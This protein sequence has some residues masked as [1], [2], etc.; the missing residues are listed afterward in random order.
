MHPK[1]K[2]LPEV[3]DKSVNIVVLLRGVIV[4]DDGHSFLTLRN[5]H[6]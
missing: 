1:G 3:A 2:I 5:S 6:V 4:N